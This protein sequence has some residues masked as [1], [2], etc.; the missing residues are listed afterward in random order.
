MPSDQPGGETEVLLTCSHKN[1]IYVK[2]SGIW[3]ELHQ[4]KT[5]SLKTLDELKFLQDKFHFQV[6]FAGE[7][8]ETSGSAEPLVVITHNVEKKRKLPSGMTDSEPEKKKPK[9]IRMT[10]D[11]DLAVPGTSKQVEDKEMSALRQFI[12]SKTVRPVC[13][14]GANCYRENPVHKE[15][16]SHPG[17]DDYQDPTPTD[18][19][20]EVEGEEEW[21]SD[22][23]WDL[24]QFLRYCPSKVCYL[25][26][27]SNSFHEILKNKS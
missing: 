2:T 22:K 11:E 27:V 17:D 16:E 13:P 14:Y 9:P 18:L 1:N 12:L 6:S 25:I 26:I 3:Q 7:E 10:E 21:I 8:G 4:G 5:V 20:E 23:F 24:C 15:E 19:E